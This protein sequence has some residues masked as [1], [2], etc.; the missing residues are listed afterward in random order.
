M[1]YLQDA[2]GAIGRA[3][4]WHSAGRA[5]P[6]PGETVA[7]TFTLVRETFNDKVR[8]QLYAQ[9]LE[10]EG[11]RVEAGGADAQRA[12]GAAFIVRDLRLEG[13]RLAALQ[14]VLAEYGRD[15]VQ[16]LSHADPPAAL[17]GFAGW[18]NRGRL[19]ARPVLVLWDAPPGPAELADGLLRAA[20]QTV[21]V[22][23]RAQAGSDAIEIVLQ[24]VRAMMAT[25]A[26]RGDALDD[27]EVIA[28]MAARI[29]QRESTVREA[30]ALIRAGVDDSP[31]L[32]YLLE[33]THAYRAYAASAPAAEVL[34][35]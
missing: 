19:A 11:Q 29:N 4:W 8:A 30:I 23:C 28:R 24:Q 20:P 10:F 3:T 14:A 6:A 35:A 1:L 5:L 21:V 22:L 15:A 33:E 34:R 7:L 9:A 2:G 16:V 27:P 13:D 18:V 17:N 31:R 32:R 12:V 25:S 26:R